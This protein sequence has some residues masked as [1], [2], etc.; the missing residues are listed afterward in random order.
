MRTMI[1]VLSFVACI[2][3]LAGAP[4]FGWR[5]KP[6]GPVRLCDTSPGAVTG[7]LTTD[8]GE[9]RPGKPIRFR[10]VVTNDSKTSVHYDFDTA[11]QF[12]IE[13]TDAQGTD[14]WRW[15]W[16]RAFGRRFTGFDL[17]PGASKTY[18][19]TWS[20]SWGSTGMF[21]ATARL[22]PATRPAIRGGFVV[23][24]DVDPS[25]TGQPE[26][27]PIENGNVVEVNVTPPI[28]AMTQFSITG[29]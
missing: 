3:A 26:R 17:K 18:T 15:S 13:V 7:T 24:P 6:A 21:T 9:Y 23:D 4:V 25:N 28:S 1:L 2:V 19:A 27:S 11:Q 8:R 14:A 5:V 20:H 12:D 16:G 22:I 29:H 10:F